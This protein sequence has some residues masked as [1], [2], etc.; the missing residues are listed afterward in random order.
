MDNLPVT[1]E[2]TPASVEV[3]LNQ[4]EDAVSD[5]DVRAVGIVATDVRDKLFLAE[6]MRTRLPNVTLFT[7]ESNSLF[8][9][10]DK[11]RTFRGMLV[12][13]TY[14]LTLQNQWWTARRGVGQLLPFAN[15]GT[16]GI[17][18]AT[19]LQLGA[20]KQMAEF[21]AP[22]GTDTARLP[23]VWI[24]V[25]GSRS[26]V[27]LAYTHD[28]SARAGAASAAPAE[29]PRLAF[30]TVI[31]L[32]LF[33]L[34][35][36]Y[37]A[38]GAARMALHPSPGGT[39]VGDDGMGLDDTGAPVG[40]TVARTAEVALEDEVHWRSLRLHLHVYAF[41]RILALLS[42]FIPAA[43]LAFTTLGDPAEAGQ[44]LLW[45]IATIAVAV[46]AG[47]TRAVCLLADAKPQQ[48]GTAARLLKRVHAGVG[49]IVIQAVVV[50]LSLLAANTARSYVLLILFLF[51]CW[52]SAAA[53]AGYH[54]A[55]ALAD[56]WARLGP[57]KRYVSTLSP[58]KRRMWIGE[59][60]CRTLVMLA[61]LAYFVASVTFAL[62]VFHAFKG[63]RHYPILLDR[64][65]RLDSG[66][67]PILLLALAG[68]GFAG[69]CSWH[70]SRI[71]LL[72]WVTSLEAAA[73][74]ESKG[75]RTFP[76]SLA[77]PLKRVR[78]RLLLMIPD[79]RGVVLLGVLAV[80]VLLLGGRFHPTLERI[81][82]LRGFE[83]LLVAA[84]TG[85]VVASAWAVYRLL[86]VWAALRRVLERVGDTPLLPAFRR[87]P[88]AAAQLTRITL[89]ERPSCEVVKTLAAE[90][91]RQLVTIY[92]SGSLAPAS[93][94]AAT[95]P[96]KAAAEKLHFV[97]VYEGQAGGAK[98]VAPEPTPAFP[99]KLQL[100]AIFRPGEPNP[101][102][103]EP[104]A[105]PAP[106][107]FPDD[108]ST[109]VA[110]LMTD[111][112]RNAGRH[113]AAVGAADAGPLPELSQVLAAIWKTEPDQRMMAKLDALASREKTDTVSI[114]RESFG[115]PARLWL[116]AAEEFAAVQVVDYV[117]WCCSRCGGW[118]SSSSR[119]CWSP[120][121]YW[122]RTRSSHRSR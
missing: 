47:I 103:P 74:R 77:A 38:W 53:A 44:T 110:G 24:S 33:G 120:S 10:P 54:A 12:L 6:E 39:D 90:Q 60:V 36:G 20:S 31:A 104:A 45:V 43:V 87:L 19:L 26:F 65:S 48:R 97:A 78:E 106:H 52:A 40:G 35:L 92:S 113:L 32:V 25:V 91:W 8:L 81:S 22:F 84:V 67:S 102:T 95:A 3:L 4:I 13:S 37:T 73:R 63:A 86:S 100:A 76:G 23:P 98:L 2:L 70:L 107:V 93:A 5:H 88:R 117:A 99:R 28:D 105:A 57:G 82:A 115:S 71:E 61:G 46:V 108:V 17:Y 85:S 79:V 21:R 118:S 50:V 122:T 96:A 80:V 14:P 89:W 119:R 55:F 1:S 116:R 83:V 72:R 68:A 30:F 75:S 34:G 41:L 42:V 62:S 114:F 11:N 15:E 111:P 9:R 51:V 69:W 94:P 49:R 59:T 29:E 112:E 16:Q 58:G 64:L 109:I 27:P 18:N 101:L 121:R 66:A 7:F 56:A